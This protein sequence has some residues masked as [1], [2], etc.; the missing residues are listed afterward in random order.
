MNFFKKPV[1]AEV[2]RTGMEL[3]RAIVRAAKL[4]ELG[5]LFPPDE[6][7]AAKLLL[8]AVLLPN[9]EEEF[10]GFSEEIDNEVYHR[11]LEQ[12]GM[13]PVDN[14]HRLGASYA[15]VKTALVFDDGILHRGWKVRVTALEHD[16]IDGVVNKI[17][18]KET[19]THR[20]RTL[21][22]W[23]GRSICLQCKREY[24]AGA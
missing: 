17:R 6:E 10:N 21:A 2:P 5:D 14:P 15:Q 19:K 20:C 11:L 13:S 8:N 18:R 3:A 9:P 24:H 16:E 12:L 1:P 23:E 4:T 22:G 7:E